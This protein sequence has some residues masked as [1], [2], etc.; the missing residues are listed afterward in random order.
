MSGPKKAELPSMPMNTRWIS[1]TCHSDL[2]NAP[3][4]KPIASDTAPITIGTRTPNRSDSRP[5]MIAPIAKPSVVA[6]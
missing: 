1:P 4:T 2:A 3:S 6:V 5:M